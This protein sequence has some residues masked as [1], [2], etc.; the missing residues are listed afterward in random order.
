MP[1]KGSKKKKATAANSRGFA[2]T[3]TPKVV[4]AAETVEE[5]VPT[6]W[7]ETVDDTPDD[8]PV[9]E[10]DTARLQAEA[11]Q[12][13]ETTRIVETGTRA[14]SKLYSE[15]EVDRRSRKTCIPISLPQDTVDRILEL[16]L[17]HTNLATRSDTAA[18]TTTD[19]FK[20][21]LLLRR[22]GMDDEVVDWLLREAPDVASSDDLMTY[23]SLKS[24]NNMVYDVAVPIVAKADETEVVT[25][26]ASPKVTKRPSRMTELLSDE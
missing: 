20:Q 12:D 15:I 13:A 17:Q 6:S 19:I 8:G 26:P 7:E 10:Q 16:E 18:D 4:K 2:T 25:P 9:E 21:E 3:S 11:D 14:F 23:M 1:S 22:L 24:D 5:E